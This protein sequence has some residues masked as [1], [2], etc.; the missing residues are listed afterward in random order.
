LGSFKLIFYKINKERT[1]QFLLIAISY[2]LGFPT[3]TFT[4]VQAVKKQFQ[5]GKFWMLSLCSFF[6]CSVSQIDSDCFPRVLICLLALDR[7]GT[8]IDSGKMPGVN[9]FFEKIF[10]RPIS[11]GSLHLPEL[12]FLCDLKKPATATEPLFKPMS[13]LFVQGNAGKNHPHRQKGI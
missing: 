9:R 11:G 2:F 12:Q 4:N 5:S 8:E 6:R 3:L 1:I 10:I 13:Q 7:C